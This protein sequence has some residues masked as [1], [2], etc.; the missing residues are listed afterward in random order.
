[1]LNFLLHPATRMIPFWNHP[2]TRMVPIWNHCCNSYCIQYDSP[3]GPRKTL[4]RQLATIAYTNATH[5]QHRLRATQVSFSPMA[6]KQLDIFFCFFCV[7]FL[8]RK[9]LML[10]FF[11]PRSSP[12]HRSL[13]ASVLLSRHFFSLFLLHFLCS[14]TANTSLFIV[15][16]DHWAGSTV[17]VHPVHHK[18]HTHI[19][20]KNIAFPHTNILTQ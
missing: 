17:A 18:S 3:K 5:K 15:I 8:S 1:M 14:T 9:S 2:T 16:Q 19:T 20:F 7:M 11:F 12:S 6:T 10:E 4:F 13:F